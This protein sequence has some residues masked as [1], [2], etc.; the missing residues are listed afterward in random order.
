MDVI[1][2]YYGFYCYYFFSEIHEKLYLSFQQKGS[3]MAIEHLLINGTKA[4]EQDSEGRTPLHLASLNSNIGQ[5]W[6]RYCA[7]VFV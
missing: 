4:N 2:L 1:A 6:Y 3:V 7:Y 5:V